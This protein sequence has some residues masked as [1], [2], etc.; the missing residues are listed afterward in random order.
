MK[1]AD[2][3]TFSEIGNTLGI[4]TSAASINFGELKR[5]GNSP[6]FYAR[7]KVQGDHVSSPHTQ[8]DRHVG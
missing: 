4:S 2:G 6:D 1:K 3:K 7:P 8:S 5:Q